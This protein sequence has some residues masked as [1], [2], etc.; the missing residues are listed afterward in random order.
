MNM[1]SIGRALVCLELVAHDV[2][3]GRGQHGQREVEA[4]AA[5]LRHRPGAETFAH[6]LSLEQPQEDDHHDGV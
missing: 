4:V 1:T 6:A 2:R 5:V 3:F